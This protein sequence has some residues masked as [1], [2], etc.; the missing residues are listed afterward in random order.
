MR[1]WMRDQ[2]AIYKSPIVQVF[3]APFG[4]PWLL[5]SHFREAH[6]VMTRRTREFDRSSLTTDS[7]GGV[8]PASHINMKTADHR[9]RQN[10]ELVKD[11]MTPA[12]LNEVRSLAA[13]G[14][15]SS[16]REPD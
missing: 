6:D 13:R 5:V 12:F 4:K 9:F 1:V 14:G 11:L 3:L 10:K 16:L 2:F 15:V 7:F 8:M